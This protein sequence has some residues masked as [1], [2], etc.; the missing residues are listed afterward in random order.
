MP[1]RPRRSLLN[2]NRKLDEDRSAGR[3]IGWKDLQSAVVQ[4]CCNADVTSALDRGA[5][6]HFHLSAPGCRPRLDASYLP[7]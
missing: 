4:L 3:Q 7:Q 6:N 1:G 5:T 2:L